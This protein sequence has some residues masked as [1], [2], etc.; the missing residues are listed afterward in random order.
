MST[1]ETAVR[2]AREL[3]SLLETQLGAVGRGL[4][5][6][7]DSVQARLP[8]E[9]LSTL[10]RIATI[11]NRAVHEH[12][13]EIDDAE[14]FA[15]DVDHAL[16]ALRSSAGSHGETPRVNHG[17]RRSIANKVGVALLAGGASLGVFSVM[18]SLLRAFSLSSEAD[19]V[20][21]AQVL[22]DGVANAFQSALLGFSLALVGLAILMLSRRRANT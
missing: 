4:H 14:A 5:E 17:A 13:F 12:G 15:A 6:K 21:K 9:L 1:I 7:V 10:R 3:E 16:A 20:A 19:A 18:R 11:R 22:S 2:A 8:S